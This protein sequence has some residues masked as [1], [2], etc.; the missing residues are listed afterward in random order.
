MDE[1]I[2]LL[3]EAS[4]LGYAGKT[5]IVDKLLGDGWCAEENLAFAY[6]ALRDSDRPVIIVFF[7]MPY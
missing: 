6:G 7:E 3:R 4:A 2:E 5:S 1:I